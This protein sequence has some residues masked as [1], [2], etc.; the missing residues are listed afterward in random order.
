MCDTI[1]AINAV[2]C[3]TGN[4][5]TWRTTYSEKMVSIKSELGQRTNWNSIPEGLSPVTALWAQL[6]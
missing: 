5:I 3:S 6:Y 4:E 1:S 2:T